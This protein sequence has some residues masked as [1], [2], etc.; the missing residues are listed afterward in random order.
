MSQP[1]RGGATVFN[2]LDTAVFPTK[3]DALFWYNLRRDGEGD[4]R[5]RHA[6]C[7]VLLGVKWVN[8]F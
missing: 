5:T 1:E 4:M 6:A 2:Q 8:H 3:H 7:P